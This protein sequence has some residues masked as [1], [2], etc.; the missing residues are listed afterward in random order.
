MALRNKTEPLMALTKAKKKNR[1]RRGK[2]TLDIG[3]AMVNKL[4]N[5]YQIK[6]YK[7]L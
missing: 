5:K 2:K 7:I 6:P 4:R 1:T 3:K